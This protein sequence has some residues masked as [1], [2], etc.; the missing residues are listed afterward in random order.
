MTSTHPGP[1]TGTK[2]PMIV[3]IARQ[4]A[5][6][7]RVLVHQWSLRTAMRYQTSASMGV[8][9]SS[10]STNPLFRLLSSIHTCGRESAAEKYGSRP[11]QICGGAKSFNPVLRIPEIAISS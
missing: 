2:V 11:A 8:A 3:V 1:M 4:V 10:N 5:R 6:T 9:P 7:I